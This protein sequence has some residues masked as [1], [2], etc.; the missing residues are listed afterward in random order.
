MVLHELSFVNILAVSVCGIILLAKPSPLNIQK[1]L[2]SSVW[3]SYC[4]FCHLSPFLIIPNNINWLNTV[5]EWTKKKIISFMILQGNNDCN[6]ISKG[7]L[8]LQDQTRTPLL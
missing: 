3:S 7:D 2:L 1:L 6:Q 8:W 5:F 4:I